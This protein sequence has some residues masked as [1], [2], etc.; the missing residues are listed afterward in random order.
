MLKAHEWVSN[1]WILAWAGPQEQK[2][3]VTWVSLLDEM[4]GFGSHPNKHG[5]RGTLEPVPTPSSPTG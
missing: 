5:I 1:A 3:A 2:R 4:G